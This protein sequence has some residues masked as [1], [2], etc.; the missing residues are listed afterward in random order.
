MPA[1]ASLGWDW[2]GPLLIRRYDLLVYLWYRLPTKCLASLEIKRDVAA[3]LAALLEQLGADGYAALCRAPEVEEMVALWEEDDTRARRRLR[4]L[5]D[6]SGLEPP[7]T[8]LLAWG[9]VMGLVEAEARDRGPRRWSW[10]VRRGTAHRRERSWRMSRRAQR[11]GHA[12]GLPCRT[13][14]AMAR[15]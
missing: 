5:L 8:E 11:R 12:P 4:E 9:S 3:A 13:A 14:P 2:E 10:R 15:A 6:A 1:L 7:D